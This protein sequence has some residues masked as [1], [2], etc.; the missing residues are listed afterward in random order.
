PGRDA[1]GPAAVE[2][3]LVDGR[4]DRRDR[5]LGRLRRRRH[6]GRPGRAGRHPHEAHEARL[7]SPPVT[8]LRP[9]RETSTGKSIAGPSG[10]RRSSRLA[11]DEFPQ[12]CRSEPP[13]D[14]PHPIEW[15][16]PVFARLGTWCHDRRRLVLGL[17]VALFLIGGAAQGAGNAYR[18][19]FNMPDVESRTGFDVLD[20]HFDGAGAGITGTIAFSAEQGV[21]DPEVR[22]AMQQLFDEAAE[23]PDVQRV[24]S[25]YSP[26]GERQI[27]SQG[28]FAGRIAYA[29]VE[30][31]E[32]VEWVRAGEIRDAILEAAP[33]VEGVRIEMGGAIF[34]DFEEPSSEILGVAF[35]IVILVLAF[36]SVLAMGLPIGTALLGI[37]IGTSVLV[38]LS[39]VLTVPEMS[40]FIGIMIGLG[41][42]ID[43]ALLIVTR[44]REQ[45]HA[46][47]TAREA[48]AIALDTAGRSVRFAGTTVVLSRLGMLRIGV[49]FVS[50]LA[51]GAALV[52]AITVAASLTL[53][54]ALIGFAGDN[55]ER[56]RWRGLVAA[57]CAAIGLAGVGLKVGVLA[58]AAFVLAALVLLAGSFLRPFT[59]D[60]PRRP[61]KPRRETAAYRWS[62]LIQRRP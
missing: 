4:P 32:D 29:E 62:R 25:P 27:S 56:T 5:R 58:A 31:P 30:M 51:L 57:G 33:D 48:T 50:G 9:P 60:V 46:G 40:S 11:I 15:R 61:P 8:G 18:D 49:T 22:E 59:G 42:G 1:A 52:V 3:R 44:Y 14:R 2:L 13:T 41:V 43:Y 55:I 16:P 21:D 53:L 6:H 23:L 20:E 38:A 24:V 10:A 34:A 28:E 19:E 36:G 37:G 17:W 7:T 47:H 45:R 12:G 39:H 35:A 26:E 54:P